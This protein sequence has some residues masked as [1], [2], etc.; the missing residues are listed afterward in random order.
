MTRLASVDAELA[1]LGA[2]LAADR[3]LRG[4]DALYIA[5]AHRL[6]VP[7]VTWDREQRERGQE[8]RAAWTPAEVL[9]R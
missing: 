9:R 1:Q 3:H 8:V 2:E 7:L 6:S 5:L 4:A